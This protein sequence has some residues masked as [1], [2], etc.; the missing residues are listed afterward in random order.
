MTTGK[1]ATQERRTAEDGMDPM[2]ARQ[3]AAGRQAAWRAATPLLFDVALPVGLYYLLSEAGMADMPALIVSGLIPFARALYSVLRAGK[4]DYLAMMVAALFVLSLIL[5]AVT[6]SPKF[7]LVK[8]SFG[9]A[10]TGLWCLASALTARPM[11]F[12]TARPLLTKGRAAA[13]RCWDQLARSSAEFRSIQRRLAVFWGIGLLVEAAV[14]V[15]IAE[16]YSV[17]AAVGLINIAAVTIIVALCL[18]TGP[19]GGRRLQRILATE[20]AAGEP[21]RSA[22]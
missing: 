21:E 9:T 10:L 14:R 12:Y 6:G 3:P 17:H 11:T 13:V 7:L 5:A 1:P 8:E 4:A 16:R 20:L 22:S 19:L 15:G 2:N 18:L